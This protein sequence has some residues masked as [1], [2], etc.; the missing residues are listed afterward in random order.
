MIKTISV[1]KNAGVQLRTIS[2]KV[3][4]GSLLILFGLCL[5]VIAMEIAL[6]IWL[7]EGP[8]LE[9]DPVL[10]PS[11]LPGLEYRLAP[12]FNEGNIRTNAEGLLWRRADAEPSSR[13]ILIIGDSISFGGDVSPE[14]TFAAVLERKLR[15]ELGEPVDVWNSGTP[16]YNT[17]QEATLLGDIGPNIRPN[18]VIV[19]LCLNDYER[20]PVLNARHV[21]ELG[22]ESNDSLRGLLYRSKAIFFL[23]EKLKDMQKTYPEW[24]PIWAHYIHYVGKK[25]GWGEAKESLI[26]IRN[27]ARE[28][29]AS[30][31]LVI[32]PVE[33]Q[34][35][36]QD[37]APQT[38]LVDFANTQA[39][40]VLDL[41]DSFKQHWRD[42]LFVDYSVMF[43]TFD[44]V[45]LNKKGHAL[46]AQEI[47]SVI[48]NDSEYYLNSQN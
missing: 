39:I 37:K 31:L 45:H 38:D 32:F 2:K 8:P 34:L 12:N 21:L 14:Q 3:F 19:Q 6:R 40:P 33:Q 46:A 26:T 29:N 41:F 48:L 4:L 11:D 30:L 44:K 9:W 18:L 24:F 22:N 43:H 23:K 13:R 1:S 16:G 25:T 27:W 7:H 17:T 20:P 10:I 15:D 47:A 42:G 36:I 28:W 35:R 5:P